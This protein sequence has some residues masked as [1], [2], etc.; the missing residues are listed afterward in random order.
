MGA[1]IDGVGE[2]CIKIEGVENLV[3]AEIEI[4]PDRI[5]A[6][7]MI[8]AGIITQGEIKIENID[9]SHIEEPIDLIRQCGAILEISE[10]QFIRERT[11]MRFFPLVLKQ[12]HIQEFQLIFRRN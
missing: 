8:I 11:Q 9:P 2:D 12:R 6:I 1:K 3:S 4:I 10:Q 7:T 5:E